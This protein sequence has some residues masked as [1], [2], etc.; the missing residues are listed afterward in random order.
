MYAGHGAEGG[1]GGI[2]KKGI[3]PRSPGPTSIYYD[4]HS[5]LPNKYTRYGIS[6]MHMIACDSTLKHHGDWRDNVSR[7]GKLTTLWG[8][9]STLSRNYITVGGTR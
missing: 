2:G 7:R 4:K 1:L 5:L 6:E 8:N 3:S 9:L